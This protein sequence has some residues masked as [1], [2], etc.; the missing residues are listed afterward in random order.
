M[1]FENFLKV[2]FI[3]V[4]KN[5]HSENHLFYGEIKVFQ[6]YDLFLFSIK[7]LQLKWITLIILF[8]Y[9]ETT[10]NSAS[11]NLALQVISKHYCF[12]IKKS[13]NLIYIF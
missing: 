3:L 12:R 9:F 4:I 11:R 10:N 2:Y 8:L 13:Q 5:T 1:T 7:I 6:K